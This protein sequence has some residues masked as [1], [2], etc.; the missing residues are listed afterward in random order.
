M[1][2]TCDIQKLRAVGGRFKPQQFNQ[3][4]QLQEISLIR[5]KDIAFRKY[6]KINGRT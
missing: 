1:L 3:F 6:S 5:I 2:I 4:K